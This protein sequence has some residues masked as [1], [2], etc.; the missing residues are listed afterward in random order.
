M[1]RRLQR[2]GGRAQLRR[3]L[4]STTNPPDRGDNGGEHRNRDN[5]HDGTGHRIIMAVVAI[6]A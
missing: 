3:A 1:A 4:T 6:M 2:L 5:R